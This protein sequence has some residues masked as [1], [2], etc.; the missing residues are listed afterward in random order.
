[1]NAGQ[2][3]RKADRAPVNLRTCGLRNV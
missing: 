1:M 2:N 3:C